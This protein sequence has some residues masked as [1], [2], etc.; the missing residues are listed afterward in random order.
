MHCLPTRLVSEPNFCARP[1][2]ISITWIAWLEMKIILSTLIRSFEFTDTG[3]KIV[4]MHA[5]LT[6][7]VVVGDEQAGGQLPIN[8]KV[9]G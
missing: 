3:K 1:I 7:P 2:Y 9:L 4:A 5:V 6:Q 8:I